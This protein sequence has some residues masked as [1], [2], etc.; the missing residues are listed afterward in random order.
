[1]EI[2]ST[3]RDVTA[4]VETALELV[5]TEQRYR[6]LFEQ[7]PVGLVECDAQGRLVR[8]NDAFARMLGRAPAELVGR[9]MRDLCPAPPGELRVAERIAKGEDAPIAD[10]TFVREDGT[11][12]Q[13]TVSSA[14]RRRADG[15]V[16]T[17]VAT[18]VDMTEGNIAR[19]ELE[20]LVRELKEA[21]DEA[22]RRN[23]L[24]DA[25]L[26]TIDVGV[27]ACD[28]HGRLTMFNRATREYH[29]IAEHPGLDPAD[30]A[31][32]Y[33]LRSEDGLTPLDAADVPLYRA[34][35]DGQVNDVHLTIATPGRPPRVVR[36]DGRALRGPD[37][38]VTGAVVAMKDVTDLRASEQRFRAA[39]QNGP[40]PMARLDPDGTVREANPALRRFLS[41]P[42]TR[43][44]G[45]QLIDLVHPADR[46]RFERAL[47]GTGAL[48]VEVKVLRSDGTSIWCELATTAGRAPGGT[49]YVLAQMLDIDARKQSEAALER[50]ANQDPLTGLGNRNVLDREL[51]RMLAASTGTGACVLFI[52]LD[53]FKHVND[54]V[55]HD[56]GDAVLVE[57]AARLQ[58]ALRPGDTAT[59]IGG[60]EFVVACAVSGRPTDSVVAAALTARLERALCAPVLHE[61]RPVAVAASVGSALG[62]PGDTPG[63]LVGRADQAMYAR[64]AARRGTPVSER[65]DRPTTSCGP[66]RR[67]EDGLRDLLRTAVEHNR[68]R[69]QYQPVIDVRT[70][71]VVGAEALLR[72]RDESGTYV[73][74]DR[75][76]PLAEAE[77]SIATLG[78]WAL[79]TAFTQ[80]VAWQKQAGP[81]RE[82]VMGVNISPLQLH[83]PSL[84]SAVEQALAATGLAPAAVILEITET[85]LIPDNPQVRSV[86]AALVDLGVHLA[87]DDFGSGYA[88]PGYLAAFPFDVLKIDRRY[89][90]RLAGSGP[91]SR[92]A[93]GVFAFAREI[94]LVT[95]AEGVETPEQATAVRQAGCGLAQGYLWHRPTD[96]AA[97]TALLE[98]ATTEALRPGP[99]SGGLPEPRASRQSK[100]S[101]R[102]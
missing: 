35:V 22:E 33:D 56:A 34:L 98:R 66:G 28:E 10:R 25:V 70:G 23:S 19:A 41:L 14:V 75:F 45:R 6:A 52:D 88:S 65:P 100:H 86:M 87:I 73:A 62:R 58:A 90:S 24:L 48:P 72:L 64:K 8:V 55:G 57:T 84:V 71:L 32:H 60:D 51:T 77:G 79:N 21:R 15:S 49:P 93:R 89:T 53:D 36:C 26:D 7:S 5:E 91:A 85:R 38:Q 12:V 44:L 80:T 13:T 96:P 40:T 29:G 69:L 50:A 30:W 39:F 43:L 74:P 83:D 11:H 95:I 81:N 59:R 47:S 94:G 61:G 67:S 78:R 20:L 31:E 2:H 27:A 1:M 3:S 76:I 46:P 63:E 9:R 18:V 99:P 82:F 102:S 54:T 97:V 17:I 42:T 37:G 92:L 101:R 68:L 4:R 16:A